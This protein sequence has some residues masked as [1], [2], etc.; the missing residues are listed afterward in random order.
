MQEGPLESFSSNFLVLQLGKLRP[1][2]EKGLIQY[3]WWQWDLKSDLEACVGSGPPKKHVWT[4]LD[5]QESCNMR[6]SM[7]K[8]EEQRR[9]VGRSDHEAGL[10]P[11]N[12]EGKEGRSRK[13][14][15]RCSS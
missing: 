5:M 8:S 3:S 13:S 4:E 9:Q 14:L 12:T 7:Y 15:R 1:R 10:T 6:A 11:V 2:E